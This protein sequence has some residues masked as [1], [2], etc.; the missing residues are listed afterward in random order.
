M[1][2]PRKKNIRKKVVVDDDDETQ[3]PVI[4]SAASVP[5]SEKNEEAVTPSSAPATKTKKPKKKTAVST[6]SFGD[7]EEE[8]EEVI[9]VK[10]SAA[11]RRMAQAIQ[12]S[13]ER[14]GDP[15]ALAHLHQSRASTS[16][17]ASY[18][19]EALEELRR[20]TLSRDSAPPRPSSATTDS[21]TVDGDKLLEEKFPSQ[22]GGPTIIPDAEA[23]YRAKK[24]RERA[25][26]GINHRDEE[27]FISLVGGDDDRIVE[28]KNTRLVREEDDE[29]DDGETEFDRD[30]SDRL[31][32]GSKSQRMAEKA[33]RDAR[34]QLIEEMDEEDEEDEEESRQWELQQIRQAGWSSSSTKDRKQL[35][36]SAPVHRGIAIP[37]TAPIPS[38]GEI[39]KRL[40]SQLRSLKETHETHNKQL[41]QVRR[42]LANLKINT[43]EGSEAMEHASARYTFFQELKSYCRNLA[44]F[45]D[46]KFPELEAI[47][48]EFR[49][50]VVDRTQMVIQ[51][52]RLDLLDDLA[53]FAV[54]VE[55]TDDADMNGSNAEPDEFG[56]I[57]RVDPSELR[58]R[59]QVD[60]TRRRKARLAKRLQDSNEDGDQSNG[61]AA[62][63]SSSNSADYEG[64][65]TD[66]ELG[67]GDERD[68]MDAFGE[69]EE[70]LH[71]LLKDVDEDFRTMVAVKKHFQAWKT[72]YY[73]DYTKAYGGLLLPMVFDFYIRHEICL[74]NPFRL[75]QDLSDQTWHQIVSSYSIVHPS[76]NSTRMDLDN[77]GRPRHVEY[78]DD[79]EDMDQTLI[80][81]VV[82][83]SICPKVLQLL[84]MGGVDFYSVKQVTQTRAFLEQLQDYVD[85]EKEPKMNQILKAVQDQVVQVAQEHY[86]Q[87]V[88]AAQP[89]TPH[90]ILTAEGKVARERYLWKTLGLFRNL[91]SLRR[92][93]PRSLL[94][95]HVV[96]GLLH[97]CL[98]RLLEGDEHQ[99]DKKYK[100][101]YEALPADLRAQERHALIE[102][103]AQQT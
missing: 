2:T 98:L 99:V 11:S 4:D 44:A 77:G 13:K 18:S 41:D 56:R 70:R 97:D 63:T 55:D 64:L 68:M 92:V 42:E 57:R 27:D 17:S 69:L 12:L 7:D 72:G 90:N 83:K 3:Q 14:G 82:A 45:F 60:R 47:E 62:G 35:R 48:A 6:L 91:M 66:D 95:T 43:V 50:L 32:L 37:E 8:G 94:H 81:R 15:S 33:K 79:E 5:A 26:L 80:N 73:A 36:A 74:W 61:T 75:H 23:I 87:F 49:K 19:K 78:D 51:R 29:N 24:A 86:T 34:R 52:R 85:A 10:K 96:D 103:L 58:R 53:E 59:R 20:S 89:L 25:R 16:T 38:L 93:I 76:M 101:I 67:A 30:E 40:S 21:M 28:P 9:A 46:E 22:Y 31:A 54:V 1:F 39:K 71:N 84:S 102:R 88:Q 100:M 65:S